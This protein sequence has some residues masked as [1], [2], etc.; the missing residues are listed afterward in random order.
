MRTS[1][2]ALACAAVLGFFSAVVALWAWSARPASAQAGVPFPGPPLT[3][4]GGTNQQMAPQPIAIQALDANS[5]VVAT[6]EPRLVTRDGKTA[7]NALV[8]V[9]TH[10]L[11]RGERILPTES[12]KPP[13]GYQLVNVSE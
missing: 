3:V 9:V 12:V 7:Q 8:T 2:A 13:L 10:Y 4:V 6:R 11:V 1:P 5:F